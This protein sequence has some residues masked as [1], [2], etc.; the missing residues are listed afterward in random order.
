VFAEPDIATILGSQ[1]SICHVQNE[2][3]WSAGL[4]D[5]MKEGMAPQA[6]AEKAFRRSFQNTRSHKPERPEAAGPI[7]SHMIAA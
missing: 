3:V 7:L 4:V 5:M 1:P 2:H 6:A